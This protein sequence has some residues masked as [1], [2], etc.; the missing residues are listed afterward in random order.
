[1]ALTLTRRQEKKYS[2][3]PPDVVLLNIEL[4][5]QDPTWRQVLWTQGLDPSPRVHVNPVSEDAPIHPS[6]PVSLGEEQPVSAAGEE[7]AA[8]QVGG[9]K[10]AVGNTDKAA[11]EAEDDAEPEYYWPNIQRHIDTREGSRPSVSC[12]ICSRS[13]YHPGLC[14][15]SS[16][17]ELETME[18]LGC[19]H[20]IGRVCWGTM[21]GSAFFDNA[22]MKCPFCR[23]E[24]DGW[25]WR[26]TWT[27]YAADEL[28]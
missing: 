18:V 1:M 7:T 22:P 27:K 3:P 6:E 10:E 16:R 26:F 25:Q 13:L 2:C 24:Q 28:A 17:H 8:S 12:A 19:G 9:Q 15:A 4:D 20:V 5:D 11:Q 14:A 23:E 21:V